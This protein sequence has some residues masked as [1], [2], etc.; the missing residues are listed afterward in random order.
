MSTDSKSMVQELMH[1]FQIT[2]KQAVFVVNYKG[3]YTEAAEQAGY[4]YP[5]RSGSRLGSKLSIQDAIAY[6]NKP[7]VD[8]SML[9]KKNILRQFMSIV[10]EEGSNNMDKLRALENIA[11]I[12][13]VYAPTKSAVM[14]HHSI[15]GLGRLSDQELIDKVAHSMAVLSDM[16]VVIPVLTHDVE[17][18][19]GL[20][21]DEP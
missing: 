1:E 21:E 5:G 9:T 4:R 20:D 8:A 18:E 17:A 7:S 10:N 6:A 12:S 14:G 11:K 3:N 13:G 2:Y 19:E 16:G 15:E